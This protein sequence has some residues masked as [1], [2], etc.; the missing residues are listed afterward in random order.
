MCINGIFFFGVM[1][2][3]KSRLCSDA[4]SIRCVQ[5]FTKGVQ[6]PELVSGRNFFF[7]P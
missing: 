5:N 7:N 2:A 3:L 4:H 1:R 6:F